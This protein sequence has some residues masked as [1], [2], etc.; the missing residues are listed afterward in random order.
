MGGNV[1]DVIS[2]KIKNSY[3]YKVILGIIVL[4]LSFHLLVN[5]GFDV[6]KSEFIATVFSF[7]NPLIVFILGI[8]AYVKYRGTQIFGKSI[9]FLSL[10]FLSLFVAEILYMVYDVILNVDPYPSIADIFFFLLYPLLAVYLFKNVKYFSPT[11]HRTSKFLLVSIPVIIIL[12]FVILSTTLAEP[13]YNEFDFIYGTLFIVVSLITLAIG[14]VGAFILRQGAIGKVWILI[15][16]G[17]LL[18]NIGD[19]WYY[20]ME[21]F[22]GYDLFHPVNLFWYSGYWLT[23]YGL[24]KHKKTI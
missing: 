14:V 16:I 8:S 3:N 12:G 10:A 2:D 21:L 24:L 23:M 17:I 7:L 13:D 15:T 6:D 4:V 18:N 19:V 20:H 22:E 11:L 9:I 5:Y 1:P